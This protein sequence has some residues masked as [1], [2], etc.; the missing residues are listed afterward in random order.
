M[1]AQ[2][3]PSNALNVAFFQKLLLHQ[4]LKNLYNPQGLP[5]FGKLEHIYLTVV[6]IMPITKDKAD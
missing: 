4:T 3:F 1:T 6:L 5:K 2:Y